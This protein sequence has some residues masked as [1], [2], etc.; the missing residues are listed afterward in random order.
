MIMAYEFILTYPSRRRF[1]SGSGLLVL[2][3][4]AGGVAPFPLRSLTRGVSDALSGGTAA[5][6]TE[7]ADSSAARAL[8][9]A[10]SAVRENGLIYIQDRH[11]HDSNLVRILDYV[12]NGFPDDDLNDPATSRA[13]R[14][15]YLIII[16][17]DTAPDYEGLPGSGPTYKT[18]QELAA[19]GIPFHFC[20]LPTK[21]RDPAENGT[22]HGKVLIVDDAFC[23]IGSANHNERS[24]WHDTEDMLSVRETSR[25]TLLKNFRKKLMHTVLC[26]NMPDKTTSAEGIFKNFTD[27]LNKNVDAYLRK[28]THESLIFPYIPGRSVGSGSLS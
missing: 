2:G 18:Y 1:L 15:F 9:R 20:T 22:K 4:L 5:S 3:A 7:E 13:A 6:R 24:M 26:G 16:T 12:K 14:N 27:Q 17:S 25:D 10:V 28:E 23:M 19:T 11:F 8:Y 21:D